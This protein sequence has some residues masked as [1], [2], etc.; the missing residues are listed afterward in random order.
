MTNGL[1]KK[2]PV[3]NA[4]VKSYTKVNNLR[5]IERRKAPDL[6]AHYHPAGLNGVTKPYVQSRS[7]HVTMHELGHANSMNRTRK[8]LGGIGAKSKFGAILA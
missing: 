6:Q 8:A 5:H 3:S 1:K 7:N 2:S 4:D